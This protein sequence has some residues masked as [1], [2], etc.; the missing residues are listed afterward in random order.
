[1]STTDAERPIVPEAWDDHLPIFCDL[2]AIPADELD[3][4]IA[5]AR[6]HLFGAPD[7]ARE[8][9][10]GY[11]FSIPAERYEGTA[12]FVANERRCCAH[13]RFVLD[14]PPRGR[15][16]ELRVTGPAARE[17]LR[18]LAARGASRAEVR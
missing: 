13:L 12:A 11:A 15:P 18:S 14:V 8:I 5:F 2:G 17:E 3:A 10:G 16:L 1:M 7:A 9:E 6:T 4:H